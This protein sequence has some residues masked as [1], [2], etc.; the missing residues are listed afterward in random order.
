[1]KKRTVCILLALIALLGC[2]LAE[3]ICVDDTVYA[4]QKARIYVSAREGE[5]ACTV[6][7]DYPLRVLGTSGSFYHVRDAAGA[8]EGYIKKNLVNSE[9]ANVFEIGAEFKT[10]YRRTTS[11]TNIPKALKSEQKTLSSNMDLSSF[12]AYLMYIAQCKVGCLYQR[13]PDNIHTFTNVSLV[14]TC[15]GVLGYAVDGNVTEV[16]HSGSQP[17]VQRND[18]QKGDVVC[19]ATDNDEGI[20]DHIGIYIGQGYF[21][22]CSPVAGAVLVSYLDSGFYARTLLWGR[23]YLEKP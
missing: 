11:S 9:P 15:L 4:A 21:I 8:F 14:Q 18:L 7:P 12:K 3:S 17:F 20:T 16:G 5:S 2:S 19:F 10:T 1:M 23:R 22:H 13:W 6:Y